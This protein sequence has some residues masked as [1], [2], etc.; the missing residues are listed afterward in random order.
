MKIIQVVPSLPPLLSGI[1][2]Y[3]LLLAKSLY[4]FY[5]IETVFIV[6]CSSWQDHE[7]KLGFLAYQCQARDSIYLFNLLSKTIHSHIHSSLD[8]QVPVLVHYSG[9]GFAKRG[10]PFWLV[11]SFQQLKNRYSNTFLLT[12]FHEI[13][14]YRKIPPWTSGFWLSYPQKF[15]VEQLAKLSDESLTS[16]VEYRNRIYHLVGNSKRINC[17]PVFSTVGEPVNVKPLGMRN[18]AMVV[19][20]SPTLRRKAY[21]QSFNA[22]VRACKLLKVEYII[23]IGTSLGFEIENL[24]GLPV[25]QMGVQSPQSI[26]KILSDAFAGFLDYYQGYLAK[27]TIF[28]AYCSHGLL[29]VSPSQNDS[30]EDGIKSGE[31]YLVLNELSIHPQQR[32]LDLIANSG[33]RRYKKHNLATQT[34]VFSSLIQKN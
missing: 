31:N 30:L 14:V 7:D 21:R 18:K 19:F 6:V 10:Y 12:F 9:Y 5:K 16:K 34:S 28:A 11:K 24:N 4:E 1:G 29:T 13:H 3:A 32:E 8:V 2:D 22:L 15:A 26:S 27:S 23:D 25:R 20:G 33:Y 17:L